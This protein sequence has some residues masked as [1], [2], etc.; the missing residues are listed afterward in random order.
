[1]LSLERVFLPPVP[2]VNENAQ[3]QTNIAV[4]SGH[5]ST[6]DSAQQ[7]IAGSLSASNAV[8]ISSPSLSP[9]SSPRSI[10]VFPSPP[11]LS[12][13]TISPPVTNS[14]HESVWSGTGTDLNRDGPY[15]N[16]ELAGEAA[17]PPVPPPSSSKGASRS[18]PAADHLSAFPSS[19]TEV[20]I[21]Q[22]LEVDLTWTK[23]KLRSNSG[24]AV[25]TR[26]ENP[27]EAQQVVSKTKEGRKRK[28]STLH[29]SS[30]VPDRT[31][32]EP[33][34]A[35]I[36]QIGQSNVIADIQESVRKLEARSYKGCKPVKYL[37]SGTSIHID[38]PAARIIDETPH[39]AREIEDSTLKE[40]LSR[41]HHRMA[42]ANFYCA[43]RAAHATPYAFL[44]ELD[45]HPFQHTHQTRA[46]N[47]NKRTEVKERFIDGMKMSKL[48]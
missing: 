45:R 25:E 15:S 19:L 7:H 8:S 3:D 35:L 41:I 31:S 22:G 39:L 30:P 11:P 12:P 5:G 44:Q 20:P 10:S 37:Q 33:L 24:Q 21:V 47:R 42:L 43:Y 34:E 4:R 14:R 36:N 32:R 16:S 28:L 29:G 38:T 17:R 1:M 48:V 9:L 2:T 46:R 26:Q 6:P 23:K 40:Q 13:T 18:S 27:A